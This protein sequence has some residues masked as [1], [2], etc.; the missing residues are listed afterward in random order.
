MTAVQG[1]ILGNAVLR[2]EDPTLLQGAEKYF[3]DM[4][5]QGLGYVHF[6]RSTVAHATINSIE[7][8]DAKDMPGVIGVFTADNLEIEPHL[9]FP[10]FPPV[11]A[12]P[13]LAKGKVR[14]V[15]D[16]IAAVVAETR[17]Q[18]ADAAEAIW[19]DFDPLPAVIDPEAALEEGAALL[20]E[21]HGSNMCFET[22]IGLEDGDP[23][24]G[25]EHVS[26][27]RMVSQRLAGVPIENNG[28]VAIP[29]DSPKLTLWTPTQNP[30]AVRDAIAPALGLEGGDMRCA[31]PAVGGGFGPKAG[32]YIEQ[33]LTCRLAME[34]DRPLKW[35][36]TRS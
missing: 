10:L 18:A 11:F 26:E 29:G 34:L 30:N 15:G 27:V 32:A 4:D 14:L 22:G 25:A 33:I 12:R 31:A 23:N 2:R 19:L 7:I 21:D 24:E 6:V 1:S 5:I 36:E 8:D 3:D 9:G 16:I 35:T 28:A 20:F 13:L 17:T